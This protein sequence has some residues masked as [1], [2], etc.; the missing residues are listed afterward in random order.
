MSLQKPC[1]YCG[2][3]CDYSESQQ[4]IPMSEINKVRRRYKDTKTGIMD[5]PI[6]ELCGNV[7]IRWTDEKIRCNYCGELV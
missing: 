3:H 5:A 2:T 6:C 4:I 7:S 1:N